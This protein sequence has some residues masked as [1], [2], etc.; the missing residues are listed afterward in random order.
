MG[1]N[2]LSNRMKPGPLHDHIL[3]GMFSIDCA[4]NSICMYLSFGIANKHYKYLCGCMDKQCRLF[5]KLLANIKITKSKV[6]QELDTDDLPNFSPNGRSKSQQYSTHLNV[7][8][9]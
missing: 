5:C 6:M 3:F 7:G 8:N 9:A 4:V 2:V 1:E